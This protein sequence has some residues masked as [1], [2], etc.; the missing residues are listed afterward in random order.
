MGNTTSGTC[1]GRAVLRPGTVRTVNVPILTPARMSDRIT[2]LLD[3]TKTPTRYGFG[4]A[5]P[6]WLR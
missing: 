6:Q 1:T 4:I 3:R 5:T 2:A